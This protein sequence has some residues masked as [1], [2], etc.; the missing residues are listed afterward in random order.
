M[1]DVRLR[2]DRGTVLLEGLTDAADLGDRFGVLWDPRVGA[3]RAP[4]RVFYALAGELRRRGVLPPGTPPLPKLAP[5]SG[6]RAPELRPYQDAALTAWRLGGRRGIVVLPTGSGKTVVAM[7][8]IARTRTPALCL[9]PTKALLAQWENALAAQ[10]GGPVGC[11]GDGERRVASITVAT[12]ASAYRN[13]ARLGDHFGLVIVDEVHHFGG[14]LFDDALEMSTAPV[15]LGL[16]ATPPP[17]GPA[18]DRLGALIGP[19]VFELG[20]GDLAGEHLAPFQRVLMRLRLDADERREYDALSAIYRRAARQFAG[21][22]LDATWEDFLREAARTDEGRVGLAAWRKAGRLLAYPRCK[23]RALTA[24]LA[25]HRRDRTLIFVADNETAYAV[26]R[27]HLI[28]PI[29][30]D[31]GREERIAAL[32]QFRAGRLGALVSAQVLNEGLDVPDAEVGIIVAGRMGGREHV[33]RIG[34]LLRP[35]AGKRALIYELVVER[36]REV[37]QAARRAE[38]LA[39]RRRFAA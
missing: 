17:P 31:I 7:A 33:Q 11:F 14:G 2:F 34:R 19:V 9:V 12:F 1:S 36:S 26:A 35:A 24:L 27:E 25:R 5:P 8:A 21:N 29:T 18:R 6:F 4:G 38:G 32:E 30:C 37:A 15:R 20:I 39:S 16:T 23:Q 10:G 28:M 3:Y 13:M 22:H